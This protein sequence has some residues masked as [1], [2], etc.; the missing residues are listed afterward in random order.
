MAGAL[1]GN[2]DTITARSS[3]EG[4]CQGCGGRRHAAVSDRPLKPAIVRER[5]RRI[6]VQNRKLDRSRPK[7]V[8][9]TPART[10]C[11]SVER[12][13]IEKATFSTTAATPAVSS[14]TALWRG[15]PTGPAKSCDDR[16]PCIHGDVPC[17]IRTTSES[18]HWSA[19]G[20]RPSARN[21]PA[22]FVIRPCSR[23]SS[24]WPAYGPPKPSSA[25]APRRLV[26]NVPWA[27]VLLP[28][29]SH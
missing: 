27:R 12:S 28:E 21:W 23:I 10:G 16:D 24:E 29:N 11:Q 5:A 3:S 7:P 9:R 13:M 6:S 19:C 20:W 17:P 4:E 25:C 18:S 8:G 22:K 14:D 26:S 2:R 15:P 1:P